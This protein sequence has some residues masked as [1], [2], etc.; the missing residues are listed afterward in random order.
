MYMFT[1]GILLGSDGHFRNIKVPSS[2]YKRGCEGT[3]KR[4]PNLEGLGSLWGDSLSPLASLLYLNVLT[5]L[6]LVFGD[7]FR[8]FGYPPTLG[9]LGALPSPASLAL[10]FPPIVPSRHSETG[11]M[12]HLHSPSDSALHHSKLVTAVTTSHS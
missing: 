3:C 1:L 5:V 8:V 10:P 4:T 7:L 11:T 12:I 6:S 9:L 2:P